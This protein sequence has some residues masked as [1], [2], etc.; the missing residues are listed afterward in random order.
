MFQVLLDIRDLVINKLKTEEQE[1]RE[2]LPRESL[3]GNA[4]YILE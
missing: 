1:V 4:K 3:K 2:S